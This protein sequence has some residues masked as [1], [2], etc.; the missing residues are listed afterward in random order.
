MINSP[1]EEI[2]VNVC[3]NVSFGSFYH[4]KFE[5]VQSSLNAFSSVTNLNFKKP[6]LLPRLK[7]NL[8]ILTM[9]GGS[10]LVG[11]GG[12]KNVA[13]AVKGQGENRTR[14]VLFT[15]EEYKHKTGVEGLMWE[16]G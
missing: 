5:N 16:G 8:L 4:E 10:S 12:R 3:F 15:F 14:E 1:V 11:V 6:V 7:E 9:K 2:L 13:V